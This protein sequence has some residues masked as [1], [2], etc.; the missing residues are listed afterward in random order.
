VTFACFARYVFPDWRCIFLTCVLLVSGSYP[1]DV[2]PRDRVPDDRW[3]AV[4]SHGPLV[5][6]IHE[7]VSSKSHIRRERHEPGEGMPGGAR[8]SSESEY[9]HHTSDLLQLSHIRVWD[10]DRNTNRASNAGS[11][12]EGWVYLYYDAWVGWGRKRELY[13]ISVLILCTPF[14]RTVW[15]GEVSD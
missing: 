11:P 14:I 15:R 12:W 8:A 4:M 2:R 7:Y 6:G 1:R 3:A 9:I 13:L 5:A 10:K